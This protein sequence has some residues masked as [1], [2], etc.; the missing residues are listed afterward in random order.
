MGAITPYLDKKFLA[1]FL[2]NSF[3]ELPGSKLKTLGRAKF[4][5][6]HLDTHKQGTGNRSVASRNLRKFKKKIQTKQYQSVKAYDIGDISIILV[7][8]NC[9]CLQEL[10]LKSGGN[11]THKQ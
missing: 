10:K 6:T 9:I 8:A 4:L 3:I 7:E 11:A 5:L 1:I 2:Y